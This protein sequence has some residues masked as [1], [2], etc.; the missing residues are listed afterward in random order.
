MCA[1][2]QVCK[3]ANNQHF[4]PNLPHTA[5]YPLRC[6]NTCLIG[7]SRE[8]RPCNQHLSESYL[9]WWVERRRRRTS[10]ATID[11]T[12]KGCVD[13]RDTSHVAPYR[14][15]HFLDT[16]HNGQIG[17]DAQSL[18]H[19]TAINTL[20]LSCPTRYIPLSSADARCRNR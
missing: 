1:A 20:P 3:C 14:D 6:C 4:S 2:A 11:T 10:V 15:Q 19:L 12:L 17:A 8:A 18:W 13:P 7:L 5:Y 9:M 16:Y